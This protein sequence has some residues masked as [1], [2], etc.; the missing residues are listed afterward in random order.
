MKAD[1]PFFYINRGEVFKAKRALKFIYKEEYIE[2]VY[3]DYYQSFIEQQKSL[4]NLPASST[5][6]YYRRLFISVSAMFFL[7][8]VGA[9][10]IVY[11]IEPS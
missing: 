7:N 10:A 4:F 2:Q 6:S 1:S 8:F 11:C 3:H 5:H 9:S